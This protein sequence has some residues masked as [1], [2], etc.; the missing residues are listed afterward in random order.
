V[1]YIFVALFSIYV[2]AVFLVRPFA[3]RKDFVFQGL[4]TL[5]QWIG[6]VLVLL[7]ESSMSK[8][9]VETNVVIVSSTAL[10][11][12]LV[13]AIESI[14]G[15]SFKILVEKMSGGGEED[16]K[17]K[18]DEEEDE[19]D[20][21]AAVSMSVKKPQQQEEPAHRAADAPIES[22]AVSAAAV[23]PPAAPPP[24]QPAYGV[25][26]PVVAAPPSAG[27][28]YQYSGEIDDEL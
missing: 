11:V 21:P 3:T 18:D 7:P 5:L 15:N 4:I 23:Q 1:S 10:F 6:A 22:V 27:A 9:Q 19:E 28:A 13:A 12:A 24:Q 20:A 14:I 2:I 16:D 17:G 8:D 25:S 26:V